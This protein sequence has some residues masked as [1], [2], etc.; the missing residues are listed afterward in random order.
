MDDRN[1]NTSPDSEDFF[2]NG[3]ERCMVEEKIGC[4]RSFTILFKFSFNKCPANPNH[5][6]YEIIEKAGTLPSKQVVI[7]KR[8]K[9]VIL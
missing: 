6:F 7:D 1:R 2:K 8:E 4:V 5:N 9:N 3:S